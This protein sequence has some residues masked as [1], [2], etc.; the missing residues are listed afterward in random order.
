VSQLSPITLVAPGSKGLN[1]EKENNLLGPEWA[2]QAGNCIIS[3]GGRIASRKGWIDQTATAIAGT[4]TIDVLHE[5]IKKDG[6]KVII[7]T[8]NN[9]IYKNFSDFT[10]AANDITS[11]T[12]PSADN[13]QFV[14]YNDY[15]IGV[16]RGE[17]PIQWQNSGDFTDI[18]FTGTGYDGNCICAAFGRV[19]AADA[20][21]QTLRYSSLLGHDDMTTT[22]GAVDMSKVWTQ[23]MDEIV[24]T[25]ALGSNLIVF[26]KNHIILWADGSGSE[27]GLDP[28]NMYVVDTIEG[29]G[30][31][32]R[33]SI[34]NIGEGDLWFLSRHGVQS[35]GRVIQDKNNP[36]AS[37]TKNIKTTLLGLLATERGSDPNLDAVR[38]VHS[39]EE[40]MYLL[41]LP[42]SG[43]IV[44]VDTR[45]TFV[46]D[47]GLP[48]YPVTS[49]AMGGTIRGMVA[50]Q[51]GDVLLGSSGV[52]GKYDGDDDDGTAF[53]MAFW[54][55]WLDLGDMNSRLKILKEISTIIQIGGSGA[56]DYRWEFDFSGAELTKSLTYTA[57]TAAEYGIAQYNIDEYSG[58][59]TIQRKNFGASGQGQFVRVGANITI[60]GFNFTLQQIQLLPKI[61]RVV[62]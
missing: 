23:G 2:T 6:T 8:A 51:N 3:R 1:L 11:S 31:I 48:A 47:D 15:V 43:S 40:A 50:R 56:A 54:S 37:V 33:D 12:A 29:T 28:N 27:I 14:N 20:D 17:V 35:L 26:G 42:V 18:V 41:Q 61:G 39:P 10:D 59:L 44:Y 32:A 53:N 55:A 5:Y 25:A 19:W 21:L 52:V 7:S 60:S 38:S 4:H 46:D 24:A 45:N 49:W 13:W 58:T 36:L 30:C 57:P 22:G 16:Q 62:A 9:K 34:Q